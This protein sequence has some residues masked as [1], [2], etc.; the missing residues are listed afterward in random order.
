MNFFKGILISLSNAKLSVSKK[1]KFARI[2]VQLVLASTRVLKIF[3]AA[4][5]PVLVMLNALLGV[6]SVITNYASVILK[7]MKIPLPVTSSWRRICW[8]VL[9]YAL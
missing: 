1:S 9:T 6:L 3:P 2:N 7:R 5:M 8:N 4:M